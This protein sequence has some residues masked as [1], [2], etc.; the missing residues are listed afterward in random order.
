L[1]QLLSDNG[2]PAPRRD[3]GRPAFGDNY[4]YTAMLHNTGAR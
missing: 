2:L 4:Y 1:E 3:D